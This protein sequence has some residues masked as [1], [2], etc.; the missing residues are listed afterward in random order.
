MKKLLK[1]GVAILA[2]VMALTIGVAPALA[3]QDLPKLLI[4]P[5]M[6]SGLP[7]LPDACLNPSSWPTGWS[8]MSIFGSA[9]GTWRG[10]TNDSQVS[11]CM[12]NLRN[13]GKTLVME[14][15]SLKS[16]CTT[17]AVC[18]SQERDIILRIKNL[19]APA[20]TLSIDEP[21]TAS[22]AI[23]GK[24]YNDAVQ[25][26]ANFIQSAR[27]E[28]GNIDI[29]VIEAFPH[30]TANGLAT[31]FKDVNTAAIQKTGKGIQYG[32]VDHDWNA[33]D[34]LTDLITLKTTI[35]AAGIGYEAMFWNANGSP[36]WEQ[37][38]MTQGQNYYAQRPNG[39]LP[40][41]YA[42]SNW[43]GSPTTANPESTAGT[44]THS[45]RSFSLQYLPRATLDANAA[46]LPYQC[47]YSADSRFYLCYQGDG[48][49]VLYKNLTGTQV[50][51]WASNTYGA[52]LGKAWMQ[53]DGN[54][55]I[56]NASNTPIWQSGTFGNNNAFLAVQS[57]GNMTI[58]KDTTNTPIWS[59]NTACC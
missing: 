17:G 34:S 22:E 47:A 40:D 12:I 48:N 23:P 7:T 29:I 16:F 8:R 6:G 45:V 39:L 54:L 59:T 4:Q 1:R 20:I 21:W 27:S 42:I 43:T 9:T 32:A 41:V 55:V 38:L 5:T 14:T 10:W 30:H 15:W 19:G 52:T 46:L 57:D 11:Q 24:T 50:P 3:A 51:I 2:G 49:L 58:Y 53:G 37:G 18:W 56:Y 36:T 13:A 26:T 25:E 31:F 44:F 33:G 28:L 35:N